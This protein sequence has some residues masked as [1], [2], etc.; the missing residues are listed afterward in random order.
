MGEFLPSRRT[1]LAGMGGA[2]ILAALAQDDWLRRVWSAHWIRVPGTPAAEYGVYHF[3]RAF[4]LAAK[5]EHFVV[6]ASADNRYQLFANGRRVASGPARGDLF[7]WRYETVDLAPYLQAGRNVLAAVVWNFGEMAPEAQ[8]TFETGFLL[9]GDGAAERV[10]DTG[11][12]LEVRAQRGVCA[13]GPR[14]R[15]ACAATTPSG[16]AE[17]V[18]GGRRIRGAGRSGISTMPRGSRRR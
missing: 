7:H 13:G 14:R 2:P 11:H 15:R 4:D 18:D 10:A 1:F 5:P 17:R 12:K 16:P 9:E 8:V 6:H 3:R